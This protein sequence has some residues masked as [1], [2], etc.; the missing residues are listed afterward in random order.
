MEHPIPINLSYLPHKRS[1]GQKIGPGEG[2]G[3]NTTVEP[4]D[5]LKELV[6]FGA[7]LSS[8]NDGQ[9]G[10]KQRAR[11]AST[12]DLAW[13]WGASEIGVLHRIGSKYR[14]GVLAL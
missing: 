2:S 11:F 9:D 10:A 7:A 14:G 13:D 3:R 8:T 5:R 12:I 1:P 4:D 6:T